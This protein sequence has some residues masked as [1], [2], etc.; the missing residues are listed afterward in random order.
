MRCQIC[1]PLIK[2]V[3]SNLP[4]RYDENSNT[5][6]REYYCFACNTLYECY[7]QSGDMIQ[8]NLNIVE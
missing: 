6:I 7:S 1:E 8:E 3:E 2:L 5:F 4:T